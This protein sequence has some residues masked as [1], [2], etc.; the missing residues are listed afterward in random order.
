MACRWWACGVNLL[1]IPLISFVFVPLVL[2]GALLAWWFPALDGLPFG[3][4]AALYEWLWPGLV[5]AA[6]L[7]SAS[8]RVTPSAWWFM[9][10][11]P[12][13]LASLWRWPLA[14]RLSGAAMLLPLVFM[15]SRLPEFGAVR[16]EVL[17]AGRGSA[18]LIATHAHVLVYDTGD[19]W[20]SH[21][22]SLARAVLPALDAL[23]IRRVDLL[24]LPRLDP[25][26]AAGAAL[27]AAERGVERILVGGGWPGSALPAGAC[28]DVRFEWEGVVLEAFAAGRHRDHCVLRVSTGS[29]ALLLPGDLDAAAERELLARLP[30]GAL[31]SEV[32]LM[33]RQAGCRR[34]QR[35]VD[36]GER[37]GIG[38]CHRRYRH[39]RRARSH[40]R[41]LA[42]LRRTRTRYT[43]ARRR[44]VRF[45]DAGHG[46][47]P[48]GTLGA[49]SIRLAA[50]RMTLLRHLPV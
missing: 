45:R 44:P 6:D 34:V 48:H 23:G 50:L 13:A 14:L 10:A 11:M 40:H 33:S 16:V 31:A 29:H 2:A 15:P 20:N 35:R 8:W 25:D 21:G 38:H 4:A 32:V 12:A 37:R 17:D 3:A 9:L 1:A 28:R 49:S 30:P 19:S 47:A 24:V 46:R 18:V 41:A 26:R 5:W 42:R 39:E 7:E 22:T 36:R 43:S 27:L